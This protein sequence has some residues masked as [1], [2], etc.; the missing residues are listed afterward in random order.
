M[1]QQRQIVVKA[2]DKQK[3]DL[4]GSK[5]AMTTLHSLSWIIISV[6]VTIH[7]TVPIQRYQSIISHWIM[8]VTAKL[9][10]GIKL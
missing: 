1:L 6:I 5:Y 3:E 10:S 8:M 7:Q 4:T 2:L 9:W